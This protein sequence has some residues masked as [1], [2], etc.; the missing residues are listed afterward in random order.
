MSAFYRS[1]FLPLHEGLIVATDREDSGVILAPKDTDNVLGVT[2]VRAW[3]S[4]DARV[5][6]DVDKAVVI[7]G[8][9]EHLVAGAADGVH[10]GAIGALRVDTGGL[11]EELAGDG[12]PLGVL[13]VGAARWVLLA[14]GNLE[15][16]E[17]VG[18]AVGANELG[19]AAP[20]KSH[21]VRAV[22]RA[23]ALETPVRGSVDI[24]GVVVGADS[25]VLV[26]WREG[27]DLDP[28]SGV[29]EQVALGVRGG[30]LSDRDGTVISS[31]SEPL[32]VSADAARALGVWKLGEG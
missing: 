26:V 29:L 28:L 31:D 21:N 16:E 27:H 17:L 11:P 30:A 8:C 32:V 22:A 6:E 18:T 9:E 23:L 5:V 25:Q 3:L 1:A 24:D 7:A 20:V 4:L 13:E 14:A 19:V 15:E 2:T 12:G 10:V